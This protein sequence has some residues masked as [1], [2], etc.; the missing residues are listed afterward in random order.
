MQNVSFAEQ[1]EVC[2]T[3]DVARLTGTVSCIPGLTIALSKPNCV[4]V[5][6]TER[7]YNRRNS[8][9]QKVWSNVNSYQHDTGTGRRKDFKILSARIVGSPW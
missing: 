9:Q 8:Y 4:S 6:F 2:A 3:R 1:A 7:K 5:T